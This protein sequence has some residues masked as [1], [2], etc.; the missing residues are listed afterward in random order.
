[1]IKIYLDEVVPDKANSKKYADSAI[2][3]LEFFGRKTLDQITPKLCGAYV[4]H[5]RRKGFAWKENGGGA[6]RDLEDFRAAINY[7]RKRGLHVENIFI[8]LPQAGEARMRWLERSEV[9]RLL[10]VCLTTREKQRGVATA[11]RPLHHLA[12]FIL[13]GVYT[14]SR[15]SAI[16][17]LSW[18]QEIGRGWV[19]LEQGLIYRMKEGARANNKRQPPVPMAPELWRLMRRWAREDGARGPVVA[20][21]G[22]PV[23]SIKVAMKRAVGLAGSI[24]P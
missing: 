7:H 8:P 15:P 12:R 13:I 24:Q 11:K 17:G 2:R 5:R 1:V 14:G 18:H 21:N 6:R 10:W 22:E 19:D 9:A 3:L 16:L 4:E 23:A 20:F